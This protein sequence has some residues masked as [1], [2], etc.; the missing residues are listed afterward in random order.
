M[1]AEIS[2]QS[3]KDIPYKDLPPAD[4]AAALVGVGLP[5]WLAGA[6]AEDGLLSSEQRA[7]LQPLLDALAS[8]DLLDAASRLHN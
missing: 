1:A 4:Y 8:T 5:G 6:L 3:G 2:R 7:S